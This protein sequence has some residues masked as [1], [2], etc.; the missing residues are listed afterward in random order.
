[1]AFFW[2][3]DGGV[4]ILNLFKCWIIRNFQIQAISAAFKRLNLTTVHNIKNIDLNNTG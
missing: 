2:N 1:M 4:K 3:F